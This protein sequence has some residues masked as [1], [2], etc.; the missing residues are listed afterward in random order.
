MKLILAKNWAGFAVSQLCWDK[1]MNQWQMC[2]KFYNIKS[3][4]S[5]KDRKDYSY[6][7]MWKLPTFQVFVSI[8]LSICLSVYQTW[9]SCRGVFAPK[10]H[11][12]KIERKKE[13]GIMWSYESTHF[14]YNDDIAYMILNLRMFILLYWY[15]GYLHTYKS[16]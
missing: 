7:N 14:T 1:T 8:C 2:F 11:R 3:C 6:D 15:N 16:V 5:L 4:N 9:A 12:E 10:N 13:N